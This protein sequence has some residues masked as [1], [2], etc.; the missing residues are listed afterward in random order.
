M[1]ALDIWLLPA[2]AAGAASY[3]VSLAWEKIR[4]HSAPP[5]PTEVFLASLSFLMGAVSAWYRVTNL[6]VGPENNVIVMF[7]AGAATTYAWLALR[8]YLP[9]GRSEQ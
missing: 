3:L 1:L 9:G 5:M 4:P 2:I 7:V 8:R 6:R